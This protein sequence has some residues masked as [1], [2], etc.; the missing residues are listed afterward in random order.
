[1][2]KEKGFTLIELL[3]VIVILAILLVIAVPAV[4]SYITSSKKGSF[5]SSAK[6]FLNQARNQSLIDGNIPRDKNEKVTILIS[7]LDMEKDMRKSSYGNNWV[8]EKSYIVIENIGSNEVPKYSY[9]I[10]LEDEKG[11]CINL[12]LEDDLDSS[13]VRKNGCSIEGESGSNG[14]SGGG[15]VSKIEELAQTNTNELMT[16]ADGNIH[17]YGATP[18]NYVTFN[19]E[20]AG[21]RILGVYT[22]DGERRIKLVRATSIGN[23]SWDNKNTSTGASSNYGSNDWTDARLMKLLNPGYEEETVGGSLY[24]NSGSGNCYKGQNNATTTCNF[25]STGLTSEAKSMIAKSTFNIGGNNT[26]DVTASVMADKEKSKTWEGYVGLMTASDY[27]YA[28]D[29]SVCTKTLY[30]YDTDTN[31]KGTNYLFD[32]GYT[33]W[34]LP[35]NTGSAFNAVG[36]SAA[37]YVG[38]NGYAYSALGVRPVL[39]LDSSVAIT[40]DGDGTS[41]NP[42]TLTK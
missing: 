31:C 34:L 20:T 13:D 38:Y 4:S 27:G 37:G 14:S 15:A 16:D 1:M 5:I 29:L 11:Y 39:Y 9:S 19:G 24:W 32:S 2:R 33:E 12:T 17:Y 40:G 23:Y 26:S 25:E 8:D 42:F 22:V 35:Y 28:S 3:A 18:K 36:R 6:L 21:W 41:T 30:N 10:A 7:D